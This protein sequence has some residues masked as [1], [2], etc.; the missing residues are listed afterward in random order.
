MHVSRSQSL[1][2]PRGVTYQYLGKTKTDARFSRAIGEG[3]LLQRSSAAGYDVSVLPDNLFSTPL[4]AVR[5]VVASPFWSECAG[6]SAPI[7][8]GCAIY[9][10]GYDVSGS[11]YYYWCQTNPCA[12]SGSIPWVGQHNT[13]WIAR[14]GWP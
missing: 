5:D 7:R 1:F 13:A 9:A 8:N 10:G 6:G 2:L 4:A 11:G 3:Y 12:A 14:F